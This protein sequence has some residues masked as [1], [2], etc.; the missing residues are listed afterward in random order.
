VQAFGQRDHEL[1]DPSLSPYDQLAITHA[2][3]IAPL[4]KT[5]AWKRVESEAV[6]SS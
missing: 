2:W 6:H 3:I 4:A 5:V 1:L